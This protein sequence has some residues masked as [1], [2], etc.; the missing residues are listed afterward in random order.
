MPRVAQLDK[1][2]GL[3]TRDI[4]A[5]AAPHVLAH[6]LGVHEN[7]VTLRLG[8]FGPVALIAP[9]WQGGLLRPYHPL[10]VVGILRTAG[11]AVQHGWFRGPR[12]GV[13]VSLIHSVTAL[14]WGSTAYRPDSLYTRP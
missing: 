12:L 9:A 5:L 7:H 2:H 1:R 3:D 8:E 11:R 14:P 6:R 13:I 4:E 10:Q